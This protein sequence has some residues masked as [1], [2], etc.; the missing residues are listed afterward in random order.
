VAEKIPDSI[1]EEDPKLLLWY[2]NAL[3]RTED[4]GGGIS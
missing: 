3:T 1:L 4:S 2:N